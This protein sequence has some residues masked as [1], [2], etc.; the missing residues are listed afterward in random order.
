MTAPA[1]N[2]SCRA[3]AATLPEL[4]DIRAQGCAD[5]PAFTF[6]QRNGSKLW[7][8]SYR[9]LLASAD[10]VGA[11]LIEAGVRP[12]DRVV[13]GCGYPS[14]FVPA[15]FGTIR[16]GAIP[17]PTP[18]PT[19]H[20][21]RRLIGIVADCQPTAAFVTTEQGKAVL[22]RAAQHCGARIRMLDPKSAAPGASLAPARV[23][24][25]QPAFLQYTSGSTG[26]PRGVVVTH[27][28][29]LANSMMIQRAFEHNAQSRFVGW[30]PLFH[31]MGLVGNVL[32]PLF[33]GAESV[34]MP[35]VAFLE[36]PLRW[37]VAIATHRAHTSGAPDFAYR[38]CAEAAARAPADLDLRSWRVA[39]NGSEP[40]RAST[41]EAF[42]RAFERYGFRSDSF[43]PCYGMAEATLLATGAA[44]AAGPRFVEVA[45][46][47]LEKGLARV[48]DSNAPG[49]RR[50]VSSGPPTLGGAVAVVDCASGAP[51][52]EKSVGEIW[53]AGEHVAQSYWGGN[54]Q[55]ARELP[56]QPGVRFH[57]TGDLG[58]LLGGELFVVGREKELLI[59]EG[60]NLH[61]HDIED[62]AR[63]AHAALGNLR[64]AALSVE[65]EAV[66]AISGQ[67]H[68][69]DREH[70]VLVQEIDHRQPGVALEEVIQAICTAVAVEHDLRLDV[71][72]V[73]RRG[74]IEVTSSGKVRR[75]RLRQQLLSGQLS[76]L[77]SWF[78]HGPRDDTERSTAALRAA[79]QPRLDRDALESGLV[80]VCS[81]IC[82]R[83][84]TGSAN[85]TFAAM[86]MS[87]LMTMR[88]IQLV[89][90]ATGIRVPFAA[91][92]GQK[93]LRELSEYIANEAT[94]KG[95]GEQ[96]A[97]LAGAA[98]AVPDRG[99]NLSNAARAILLSRAQVGDQPLTLGFTLWS[100]AAAAEQTLLL[101]RDT[102]A[103][104]PELNVR[105]VDSAAGL[106]PVREQLVAPV[107][108]H[109]GAED[110]VSFESLLARELERPFQLDAGPVRIV[111]LHGSHRRTATTVLLHHVASD[112]HSVAFLAAAIAAGPEGR[113]ALRQEESG[114]VSE[115]PAAAMVA[116][117]LAWWRETLR[118][119]SGVA[120]P[121]DFPDSA[122]DSVN[123]VPLSIAAADLVSL[124]MEQGATVFCLMLTG[125]H[126]ALAQLTGSYDLTIL[127]PFSIRRTVHEEKRVGY[128]VRPVPIRIRT[129]GSMS[130]RA[131]VRA[132]AE[133]IS[134][135]AAHTDVSLPEIMATQHR[136]E[137]GRA[138]PIQ[139]AVMHFESP[140]GLPSA[141]AAFAL[142][143]RRV[144]IRYGDFELSNEVAV[145]RG[146]EQPIE[147]LSCEQDGAVAAVLRTNGSYSPETVQRLAAGIV[148]ALVEG[149][150]DADVA[151]DVLVGL[152]SS[153]LSLLAQWSEAP[154]AE[155]AQPTLSQ[156]IAH[157]SQLL[158]DAP[159]LVFGARRVSYR[160][161]MTLSDLMVS[162]LILAYGQQSCSRIGIVVED[163]VER[164]VAMLAG[165][166]AG[167]AIVPLDAE[168]PPARLEALLASANV[169]LLLTDCRDRFDRDQPSA[170]GVRLAWTDGPVGAGGRVVQV[171]GPSPAYIVFTSGST[172]FPK[173]I[174]HTHA[175][176]ARFVTWQA[177]ALGVSPGSRLAQIAAPGFDVSLCETFG[178]LCVGATL[179]LPLRSRDLAPARLFDWLEQDRITVAQA[180]PSM[181]GAALAQARVPTLRLA[182][183]ASVGEPLS[184]SLARQLLD[185]GGAGM[186]LINLYGPS[187]VIAATAHQVTRA[188]LR[189]KRI[190][191][192]R[193]LA[194][195]R[196]SLRDTDGQLAPVGRIGEIWIST[197]DMSR[198][199]ERAPAAAQG[200]F[201]E[202][203]D[204]AQGRSGTYRSGDLGRWLGDGR[205]EIV[206]RLDNQLKIRGV[207]IEPEE[208]EGV[209]AAHPEVRASL[210]SAFER[211]DKSADLGALVVATA[212]SDAG[213]LRQYC[214][215]RLPHT[216]VP[217][218]FLLCEALPRLPN[219][220]LDRAQ[221]TSLL[222]SA[223]RPQ[224]RA[225]VRGASTAAEIRIME[226]WRQHLPTAELHVDSN[227]FELGG[228]SI[229]ALQ[230][231]NHVQDEFGV[232]LKI[233]EFLAAPTILALS[234]SVD[235]IRGITH[236]SEACEHVR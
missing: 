93:T 81:T 58:F 35:T 210:V 149:A 157:Q 206:G 120:L 199:Y 7:S 219:G 119:F 74:S 124:R 36:D 62:T 87:S 6:L 67:M 10:A 226:I 17:V 229:M 102:I 94:G 32:Q 142:G 163:P 208:I 106:V 155:P 181:L 165:L 137:L 189:R 164:T 152:T 194:N 218:I 71:I 21:A 232:S 25:D 221:A 223:P 156:M 30:L 57:A 169:D 85:L 231:L 38:L 184:A 177:A 170:L 39:F 64:C 222:R 127:A 109:V 96:P 101:I 73:V 140:A 130:F 65:P 45:R 174:L 128:L 175:S 234:S 47:S 183:L 192:G 195:R 95:T 159:A 26:A 153:E 228:H 1:A 84:D 52:P 72:F 118:D 14:E 134:A 107:T 2:T 22:E 133:S 29:A 187:E 115:W 215:S 3:P 203:P 5:R 91:A 97:V 193:P 186:R 28:A 188:D 59:V 150:R 27:R 46:D 69:E 220:K 68:V 37:L 113:R 23:Q 182:C 105:Y 154:V 151:A 212:G 173:T 214:Y 131:T 20:Q 11:A 198:G 100:D 79:V 70:A 230:I 235:R 66:A 80:G 200:Q 197:T 63:Q 76:L 236:R 31:D 42:S 180:V 83:H 227:L 148:K 129:Q 172:G 205:L 53:I 136:G 16:A 233:G 12:G 167:A 185:C 82:G 92:Y 61:P 43:L 125:L 216:H 143:S 202:L 217:S 207:R 116:A 211:A 196:I 48:V 145:L 225:V 209:L 18:A 34:L 15:F 51:L 160:E 56:G 55:G 162:R 90:T 112:F 75:S 171:D 146:P 41:L 99:G 144:A 8:S 89:E 77:R 161:L 40:V 201:V 98:A 111:R 135:A 9:E 139:T 121:E 4:L 191:I 224:S 24:S 138:E 122:A 88:L 104:H 110:E 213:M 126:L 147:L 54:A 19:S 86:G 50:L 176:M 132:V 204:F 60:R 158:P 44:H 123:R 179:C 49:A 114:G 166:K 33:I 108:E 103:R 168:L 141:L 117:D 78:R 178:A 190:P 13:V